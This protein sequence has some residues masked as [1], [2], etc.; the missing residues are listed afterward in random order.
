MY[1]NPE[2]IIQIIEN[3]NHDTIKD[4]RK[5]NAKIV[6]FIKILFIKFYHCFIYWMRNWLFLMFLMLL[7]SLGDVLPRQYVIQITLKT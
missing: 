5:I 4:N 1:G 7:E 6:F 3:P 2:I